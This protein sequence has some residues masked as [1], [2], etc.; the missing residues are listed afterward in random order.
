MKYAALLFTLSAL[1]IASSAPQSGDTCHRHDSEAYMPSQC[2]FVNTTTGFR[3]MG[4]PLPNGISIA[5]DKYR[6]TNGHTWVVSS[7]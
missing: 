1:A 3:C 7:R 4:I 6:C 5:G 2:P